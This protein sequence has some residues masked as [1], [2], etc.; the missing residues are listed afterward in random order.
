MTHAQLICISWNV[1]KYHKI[2]CFVLQLFQLSKHAI[3]DS[4][5]VNLH[6]KTSLTDDTNFR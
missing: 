6:T 4:G 5:Q 2:T 3:K 1:A